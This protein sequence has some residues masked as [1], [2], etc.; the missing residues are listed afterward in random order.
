[1]A[2]TRL[3][4]PEV[5]NRL[6]DRDVKRLDVQGDSTG[7]ARCMEGNQP[8]PPKHRANPRVQRRLASC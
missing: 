3:H 5:L 4:M 7:R 8:A 2:V 6:R 1:M